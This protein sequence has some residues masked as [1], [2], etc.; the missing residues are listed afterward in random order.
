[1]IKLPQE[2][3]N[4]RMTL[5]ARHLVGLIVVVMAEEKRK[6]TFQLSLLSHRQ[7]WY[8][9]SARWNMK[10]EMMMTF[11]T[12]TKCQQYFSCHWPVFN[13]TLNVGF[14]W[15][16]IETDTDV[17]KWHTNTHTNSFLYDYNLN[18]RV[19]LLGFDFY[20]KENFQTSSSILMA[21]FLY[22]SGIVLKT[23]PFL[24]SI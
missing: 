11:S 13:Q 15:S 7:L 8:W 20:L 4:M 23:E 3:G 9:R 19:F 6:L 16:I 21:F 10:V 1:M 24:A 22:I 2:E 18:Y 14:L 5:L 17:E 12:Q